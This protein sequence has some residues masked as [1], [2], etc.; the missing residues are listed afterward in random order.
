MA[1][2][3]SSTTEYCIQKKQTNPSTDPLQLRKCV[4]LHHTNLGL[5][6]VLLVSE[7]SMEPGPAGHFFFSSFAAKQK[8]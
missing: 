8:K 4:H 1:D 3:P 7:N 2:D 5:D 6:V